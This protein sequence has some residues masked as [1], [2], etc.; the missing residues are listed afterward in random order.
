MKPMDEC[1]LIL[2]YLL[3]GLAIR[4]F[5]RGNAETLLMVTGIRE[6][7]KVVKKHT[8]LAESMAL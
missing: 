3:I 4:V 1:R 5:P 6:T 2:A 7:M 8:E